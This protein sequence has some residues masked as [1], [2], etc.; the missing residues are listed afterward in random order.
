MVSTTAGAGGYMFHTR[1]GAA[2][3]PT[4]PRLFIGMTQVTFVANVGEPSAFVAAYATFSK[5]STDTNIQ[6]LTNSNAGAGTKVDTGIALVANSWYEAVIWS[7]PG[8][9]TV[10]ALLVRIDTGAIWYG[11]TA[12]DVPLSDSTLFPQTIGGLS[13][14]TGTAFGFCTGGYGIRSGAW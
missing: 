5:D 3:L 10:K 4:G 7:D 13:A 11:E 14:T 6:L 2:T 12:T 9:L 1:F 8:S